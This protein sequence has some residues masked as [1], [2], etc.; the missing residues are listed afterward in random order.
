MGKTIITTRDPKTG[1]EIRTVRKD[2]AP[3]DQV[4]LHDANLEARK[5]DA[6]R[7]RERDKHLDRAK[8]ALDAAFGEDTRPSRST[9]IRR[10]KPLR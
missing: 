1:K 5:H 8:E 3:D 9:R 7:A 6:A 4:S 2:T 10:R